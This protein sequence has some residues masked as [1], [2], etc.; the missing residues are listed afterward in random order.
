MVILGGADTVQNPF[1]YLAFSKTQAFSPRG[2]CR[3]FDASADGIVISEAIAVLVLKRLA[4]AERD[5]DRIYAV[6]KG[7]GASS[8]GRAKGLTAPRP[9][10]QIRA[11]RRAYAKAGVAPATVGYVEAHGTGTAAGDLAEIQALTEVFAAAGVARG[12]CALGSVKSLIGHTKCAA[13]LAGLIN[14]ALA[15]HHEV[16]PP[17]IG[18]VEPNPRAHLD[19]SPFHISARTRPWLH[20]KR[21]HPR[22]AGVSAFGFGGTN[23]HAVLEAYTGIPVEPSAPVRDWPAELLAWR[24]PIAVGSSRTSID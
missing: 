14:A 15:L 17:T 6:I 20:G 12:G 21:G 23:F 5:G 11:L 18:V 2:R 4:D 19:E 9:E 13:G 3:P 8:D 22:R 16:L 24:A 10:G 1:T 7:V